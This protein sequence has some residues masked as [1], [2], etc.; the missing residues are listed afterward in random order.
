MQTPYPRW[1]W[2]RLPTGHAP[3][4]GCN[5]HS[6]PRGCGDPAY[7]SAFLRSPLVV[8]HTKGVFS[9]G[10]PVPVCSLS[11]CREPSPVLQGRVD[12]VRALAPA[13]RT[14]RLNP[15]H[16][17]HSRRGVRGRRAPSV[18]NVLRQQVLIQSGASP[19]YPVAGYLA[20]VRGLPFQ[21]DAPMR[22]HLAVGLAGPGTDASL[23]TIDRELQPVGEPPAVLGA[24]GA[25]GLAAPGLGQHDGQGAA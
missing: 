6:N 7:C 9:N 15:V 22:V 5:F 21:H 25:I 8:S 1:Y 3:C 2:A 18:R 13:R 12:V 19:E 4:R 23:G 16:V 11:R 10:P 17:L 24:D 20:A 14:D